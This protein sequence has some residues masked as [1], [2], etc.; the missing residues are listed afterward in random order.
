MKTTM[1]TTFIHAPTGDEPKALEHWRNRHQTKLSEIQASIS[2]VKQS[3]TGNQSTMI[4]AL[5]KKK[6]KL[7]QVHNTIQ[8]EKY[9]L[10]ITIPEANFDKVIAY[11]GC[12]KCGT[13]SD[14]LARDIYN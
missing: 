1:S 11:L 3:F 13:R 7:T 14:N 9:I 5:S 8:D 2:T 6:T 10:N 12:S 4:T